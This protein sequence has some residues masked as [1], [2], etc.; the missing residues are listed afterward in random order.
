MLK[1]NLE[2]A[3]RFE[4]ENQV[5]KTPNH[6]TGFLDKTHLNKHDFERERLALD[7][8]CQNKSKKQIRREAKQSR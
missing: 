4:T 3:S 1:S 5:S 8:S 2:L 6:L 7:S